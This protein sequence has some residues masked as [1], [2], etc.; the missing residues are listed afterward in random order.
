MSDYSD[1]FRLDDRCPEVW[2]GTDKNMREKARD[3][4]IKIIHKYNL[5]LA[6]SAFLFKKIITE[7][8]DTPINEL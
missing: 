3:E 8:G 2:K 6:Q 7:L 4:I 5:S 1:I